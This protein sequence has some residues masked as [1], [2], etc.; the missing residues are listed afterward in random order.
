MDEENL[1]PYNDTL[2]STA[3]GLYTESGALV[4]KRRKS[5]ADAMDKYWRD[6]LDDIYYKHLIKK[7]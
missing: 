5:S 3:D 2:I 7:D 6:L 4:V 1:K